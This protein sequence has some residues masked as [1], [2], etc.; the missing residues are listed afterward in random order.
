[1]NEQKQTRIFQNPNLT[2]VESLY[3]GYL[4]SMQLKKEMRIY[5]NKNYEQHSSFY[6][7]T[8]F[9][10]NY[11]YYQSMKNLVFGIYSAMLFAEVGDG[12]SGESCQ[13]IDN[14]SKPTKTVA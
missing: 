14:F 11:K 6:H 9:S 4:H 13:D 5:V 1:M 3:N 12:L 2:Y 7:E 8:F 10:N